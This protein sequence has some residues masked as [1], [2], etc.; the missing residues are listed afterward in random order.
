MRLRY[1]LYALLIALAVA[2]VVSP[3]FL[4]PGY[5]E[6]ESPRK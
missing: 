4:P 2:V 5:S 3:L 6:R 1:L